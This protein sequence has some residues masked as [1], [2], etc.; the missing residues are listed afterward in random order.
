MSDDRLDQERLKREIAAAHA[1]LEWLESL[2]DQEEPSEKV[3]GSDANEQPS[4]SSTASDAPK[5][6][7]KAQPIAAMPAASVSSPAPPGP[8]NESPKVVDDVDL[9]EEQMRAFAGS[10]D[11]L[12]KQIQ[13]TKAGCLFFGIFA[14]GAVIFIFFGLPY[15]L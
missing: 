5:A 11:S 9:S 15:L 12:G 7:V 10:E 14:I 2:L 6:Q 4:E 13:R 1:H 8:A 3:A